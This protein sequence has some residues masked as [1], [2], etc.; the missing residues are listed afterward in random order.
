MTSA[1]DTT[2]T[3]REAQLEVLRGMDGPAR[4]RMALEMSEQVRQVTESGIRHR[5]PDWTDVR[6]QRELRA[7]LIGPDVAARVER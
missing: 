6:V 2:A 3:A 7:L 4:L 5:H 1:R